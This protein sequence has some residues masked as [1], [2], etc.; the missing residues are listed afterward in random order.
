MKNIIYLL[1]ATIFTFTMSCTDSNQVIDS[2]E[3]P[4]LEYTILDKGT[5][6][7]TRG[8]GMCGIDTEGKECTEKVY[9]YDYLLV[10][11][12]HCTTPPL[13]EACF[14]SGSTTYM[15]CE[16]L[17]TGQVEINISDLGV[18]G[19]NHSCATDENGDILSHVHDWECTLDEIM[20]V[21]LP[22]LV[23]EEATANLDGLDCETSEYI[24][25]NYSE[26]TCVAYC[27]ETFPDGGGW[28]K[29]VPCGTEAC[30]VTSTRW[31][32]TEGRVQA[33]ETTKAQFGSCVPDLHPCA[34]S[35]GDPFP[36]NN[37]C[38]VR[39]CN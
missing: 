37:D 28:V 17:A 1:L 4:D 10:D 5:I 36:F 14:W 23:L 29:I 13:Y 12:S 38:R 21:I 35:K 2:N 30:C 25:T 26:Q 22:I 27:E 8:S 19:H 3:Q 16:D 33:Q 20:E 31:C 15:V 18:I 34:K 24:T 32:F 6:V 7:N 11:V 9:T 39:N